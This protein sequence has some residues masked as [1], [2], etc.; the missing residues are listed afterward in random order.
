MR[1]TNQ[2]FKDRRHPGFPYS[3]RFVR[4]SWIVLCAL[5]FS[6]PLSPAL[7]GP[8]ACTLDDFGYTCAGDQSDGIASGIDFSDAAE[9]HVNGLTADITPAHGTSG[10]DLDYATSSS[11]T[12]VFLQLQGFGGS[13]ETVGFDAHGIAV[14]S[15]TST[16]KTRDLTVWA[17]G[18][19]DAFGGSAIHIDAVADNGG[20]GDAAVFGNGS[21]GH[22]GGTTGTATVRGAGTFTTFAFE[23]DLIPAVS[24]VLQSGNGGKGGNAGIFGRGGNGGAPGDGGAI[25]LNMIVD[26]SIRTSEK[27]FHGIYLSSTGGNGGNGG[28]GDTEDGGRGHAGGA[29][30][31]ITIGDNSGGD[32]FVT[33]GQLIGANEALGISVLS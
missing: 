3:G 7:A 33:T 19:I 2:K 30:G 31:D 1:L 5:L 26:W 20:S 27:K 17:N 16:S 29:G 32:L 8:D 18:T 10:I 12:D 21:N 11:Q 23:D 22:S 9:V 28:T 13:I 6:S 4:L 14:T 24:V 15:R 25:S